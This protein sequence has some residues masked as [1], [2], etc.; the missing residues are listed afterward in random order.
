M[1]EREHIYEISY[2]QRP[3]DEEEN[4][5]ILRKDWYQIAELRECLFKQAAPY[6]KVP[7]NGRT[8]WAEKVVERLA[9]LLN[10][11][12]ARYEFAIKYDPEPIEGVISINCIP[13]GG[14]M[15][16]GGDFLNRSYGQ[17]QRNPLEYSIENVLNALK[18]DNVQSPSDWEVKESGINTG[19]E[20]FVGYT[21]LDA[22][23]NN[24]DR[25]YNNWA[26]VQIGN[27]LEVARSFDHG[28]AFGS[29]KSDEE[30]LDLIP[31]EYSRL[32]LSRFRQ[33]GQRITT[34]EAFVRAAQLYPEAAKIW[35]DKLRRISSTQINEIF[36][37]IP[38]GRITPIADR[39]ARRLLE[40]N[41]EK[42]LAIDPKQLTI[43]YPNLDDSPEPP[44]DA[45]EPPGNPL[46]A[47]KPST[48]PNSPD[49]SNSP[50]PPHPDDPS[51]SMA[52]SIDVE[53]P[54]ID[55]LNIDSR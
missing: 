47:P 6:E 22:L 29:L 49:P 27:T 48:S 20:V 11:P 2:K 8:D 17:N 44:N 7:T 1:I 24:K 50:D 12:V 36:E 45:P 26:V 10:L 55:A 9:N 38:E 25:H 54:E 18:Q 41:R 31:A 53:T 35:Q 30:K 37:R 15:I 34:L 13:D 39:F 40:Y 16:S 46:N 33:E 42:I 52:T 3:L 51:Q 19:A 32:V 5:G 43:D 14:E 4:N 28:L 23:V 21:V